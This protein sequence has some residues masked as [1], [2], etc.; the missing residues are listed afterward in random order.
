LARENFLATVEAEPFEPLTFS[1][2]GLGVYQLGN[3]GTAA[4]LLK[5]WPLTDS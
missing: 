4:E 3:N 2:A 5:A 1:P